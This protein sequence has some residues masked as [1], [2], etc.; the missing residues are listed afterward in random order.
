MNTIYFD[1]KGDDLFRR[2]QLFAGNV[3]VYSRSA[4]AIKLCELARELIA[5]A[6]RPKDPLK[7]FL[8]TPVEECA[9]TLAKLKPTFIH[10]PKAKEW[11][12]EILADFGC[13]LEST[14][15]DVPRLRTAFPGDYLKSGIAYAFHPHRDTWYSAPFCQLN[16][17]MPV[18]P[19]CSENSMAIHPCYWDKPVRNSSRNYNYYQWNAQNRK[20][21]ALHIKT[22]TREQPRAEEPLDLQ[23]EVRLIC[24][25]GGLYIFSGAHLHSTVP[26][27]A[28]LVRYSID[29]RTIHVTDARS[30]RGAPNIDSECTGTSMRDFLRASDHSHIPEEIV[31]LYNDGTEVGGELT[32][33]PSVQSKK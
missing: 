16:W 33:Q 4:S 26:N 28:G 12:A 5:E 13:D 6:F 22:D 11:I 18:Y 24:E 3:F 20:T 1:W 27:T 10:H 19:I 14:Y 32:Y 21:A 17:W 15:F 8:S 25:P 9:T 29:F 31:A 2:E 7:I 30:C 23:P